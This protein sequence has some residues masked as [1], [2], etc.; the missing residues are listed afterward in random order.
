MAAKP[1]GVRPAPEQ[2]QYVRLSSCFSGL[3]DRQERALGRFT[4]SQDYRDARLATICSESSGIT[5]ANW[6][7]LSQSRGSLKNHVRADV[8]PAVRKA[9]WLLVSEVSDDDSVLFAK[10]FGEPADDEMEG[11]PRQVCAMY[12][13]PFELSALPSFH[14]KPQYDSAYFRVLCAFSYSMPNVTCCPLLPVLTK[15]FLHFLEEWECYAVLH[16][17]LRKRAWLDQSLQQLHASRVTFRAL[18][19]SHIKGSLGQ[20]LTL[21]PSGLT[22]DKFLSQLTLHWYSWPF[23]SQPFWLQARVADMYLTEGPKLLYR[24][25]LAAM[26]MFADQGRH[27]SSPIE[28]SLQE[29]TVAMTPHQRCDWFKTAF[30]LPRLPWASVLR[31]WG[32]YL[33]KIPADFTGEEVD[34][35]FPSLPSYTRH[36]NPD[37][38]SD[39]FPNEEAW[40]AVWAWLPEWVTCESPECIFRASQ[41]GYNLRTLFRK[42]EETSSL[43]LVIRTSHNEVFGAFIASDLRE[44][45]EA[46]FFGTGETFLFALVPQ[47]ALFRWTGDTDLILRANDQELIVGSGGG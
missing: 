37:L 43:V 3:V 42:C 13:W 14:L 29:F 41:D 10:A 40:Q 17:M 5:L 15:I 7:K 28:V 24:L 22:E 47:P 8:S 16:H 12:D 30:S 34:S 33:A 6:P 21:C 11:Q 36:V 39:I 45:H 25:G 46:Q 23:Y 38:S 44:R 32:G 2:G 31:Q 19:H 27:L 18:C 9:L 4:E 26:K 35:G 20:L 1:K